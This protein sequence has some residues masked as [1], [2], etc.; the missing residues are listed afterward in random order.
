MIFRSCATTLETTPLAASNAVAA[1][2][3]V[4]STGPNFESG[5]VTPASVS[6]TD[7]FER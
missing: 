1:L 7:N 2:P 4:P 3:P 6:F 5:H